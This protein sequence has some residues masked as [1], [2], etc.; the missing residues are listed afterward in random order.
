VIH[1]VDLGGIE[2]ALHVFPQSKDGRASPG[3]VT[4]D[5]LEDA[6][7]IMEHVRHDVH[8]R[9]IPLDEFSVVPDFLNNRRGHYVFNFAVFGEHSV[10]LLRGM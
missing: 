2:Q 5:A 8:A 10:R 3:G 7:T 6:R 4:T 1:P 9:L